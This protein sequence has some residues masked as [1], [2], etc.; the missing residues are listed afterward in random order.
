[1]QNENSTVF[2]VTG[3]TG[4]IGKAI[5]RQLAESDNARVVLVCRDPIKAERA[6]TEIIRQTGNPGVRFELANL[7]RFADIHSLALRWTGPLHVLINNAACTPRNRQETPEGIEMQ[8]AT[9][10]LGYFWLMQAFTDILKSSAPAQIINVASYWAG[11]LDTSDLEFSRRRYDNDSAYRQSKQINRMLSS[12]FAQQ[13][14]PY[15]IAVNACHP[16]DVHSTLSHNLGFGGH[17]TPDQAALT[18]VWLA[19]RPIAQRSSGRYYEHKRDVECSFCRDKQA[20]ADVYQICKNYATQT[21]PTQMK[22]S[23]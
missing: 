2:L 18:P 4:A 22:L 8:F 15:Q 1:M 12:A 7:S 13:L 20:V 10:V 21:S 6:V 17:E 3:A 11:G 14:A 19:T 5:A 16:G 23:T 9:N